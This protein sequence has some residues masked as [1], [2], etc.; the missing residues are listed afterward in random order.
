MSAKLA[1]QILESALPTRLKATAVSMVLSGDRNGGN[2]FPSLARVAWRIGVSPRKVW[3][4]V[5][6]LRALNVLVVVRPGGGRKRPTEYR[7]NAE[8]LPARDPWGSGK[9]R[10]PRTL[11]P[12][13]SQPSCEVLGDV[14]PEKPR[15]LE[16][17]TSQLAPDTSQPSCEGSVH[18]DRSIDRR[19][20]PAARFSDLAKEPNGTNYAV[21]AKIARTLID[22]GQIKTFSDLVEATKQKCADTGVD[23]GRHEAVPFDV[24][25]RACASEAI[26]RNLGLRRDR[27]ELPKATSRTSRR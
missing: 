21:V 4:D 17:D 9:P 18:I 23:Y 25:H 15:K 3:S 13:T 6:E 12:D 2:I 19:T 27:D 8:A 24:V 10:K 1:E 26:K 16:A 7:L 11:Q 5:Q 14:S 20:A 22:E